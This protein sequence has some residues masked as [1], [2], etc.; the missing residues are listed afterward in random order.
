MVALP[1]FKSAR[2]NTASKQPTSV[3]QL[4]KSFQAASLSTC[5]GVLIKLMNATQ[6]HTFGLLFEF[7]TVIVLDIFS[8]QRDIYKVAKVA[9]RNQSDN[10]CNQIHC[11]L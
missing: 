5:S 2:P 11:Y 4:F 1:T 8:N 9:H 6:H 10:H 3:I 7:F